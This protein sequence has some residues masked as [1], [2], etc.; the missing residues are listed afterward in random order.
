MA[1]LYIIKFESLF[2]ADFQYFRIR[3]FWWI[4]KY[5]TWKTSP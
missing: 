4:F 5:N 1:V 3:F 2:Y